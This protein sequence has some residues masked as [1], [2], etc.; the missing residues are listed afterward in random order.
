MQR[1]KMKQKGVIS[2]PK[3]DLLV[4]EK[5]KELQERW[6]TVNHADMAD[7]RVCSVSLGVALK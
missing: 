2:P 1:N 4:L 3:I 6:L 5:K 7:S